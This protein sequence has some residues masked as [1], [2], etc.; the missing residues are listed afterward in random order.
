VSRSPVPAATRIGFLG[1][2]RMGTRIARNIGAAGFPLTVW[3]RTRGTAEAVADDI[4]ATL[5]DGPAEVAANTD[6]VM[7]MLSDDAAVEAV[8]LAEDGILAGIRPGAVA[9]DLSTVDPATS[10]R[11]A[12]RLAERGAGFVDSPVSGSTAAAEAR[13]LIMMAG[14]QDAAVETARPALEAAAATVYHLGPVGSGASMKLAVN[15]IV[16]GLTEAL[17]EAL[18]LAERA[19]IDRTA[20]YDVIAHSAV[21]APV[22]HYRRPMFEHPGTGPVSFRLALG[23]KDLRLITELAARLGVPMPQ[24]ACNLDT[25]GAA[26]ADGYADWDL[27]GVAEWLRRQPPAS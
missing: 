19:G 13:T 5:G 10:R 21:A 3:N 14:G 16:Y 17:A 24:A 25:L 2:G 8:Y 27:A 11:I 15:G 6:V 18:V 7:T 22:V 20:A 1:L 4:S 23:V 9:V 12:A 26:G